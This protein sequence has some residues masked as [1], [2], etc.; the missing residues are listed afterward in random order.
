MPQVGQ[1]QRLDNAG[2][3][4]GKGI[5]ARASEFAVVTVAQ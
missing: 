3:D 4:Q 2:G 1:V 5:M